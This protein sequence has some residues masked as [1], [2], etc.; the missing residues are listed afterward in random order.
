[1]SDREKNSAKVKA[2]MLGH[3]R[4]DE[5][6][7]SLERSDGPHCSFCGK[8]CKEVAKLIAGPTVYI[9][10]EC[11]VIS[12]EIILEED[13]KLIT[14]EIGKETFRS[15]NAFIGELKKHVGGAFRGGV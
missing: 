2:S 14:N 1:M 13:G 15:M 8:S 3:K 9:C 5:N 12:L 4:F 10:N 7:R 6:D 11:V